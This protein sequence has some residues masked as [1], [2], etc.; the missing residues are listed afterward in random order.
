MHSQESFS[1]QSLYA[2]VTDLAQQVTY[3]TIRPRTV[4]RGHTVQMYSA[5]NIK[6]VPHLMYFKP[7]H[8]SPVVCSWTPGNPIPHP[9][10]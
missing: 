5:I 8:Y 9:F 3:F 1:L 4:S 6:Y 2:A 10:L 7:V